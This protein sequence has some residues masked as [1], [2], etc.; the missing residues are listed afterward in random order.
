[1]IHIQRLVRVIYLFC[2]ANYQ[3]GQGPQRCRGGKP[4]EKLSWVLEDDQCQIQTGLKHFHCYSF[5]VFI[6]A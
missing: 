3:L 4:R 5:Y 6:F 1:M 2:A